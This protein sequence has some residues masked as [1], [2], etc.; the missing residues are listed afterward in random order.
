MKILEVLDKFIEYQTI[1]GLTD[2]TLHHNKTHIEFFVLWWGNKDIKNISFEDYQKYIL[3]LRGKKKK[4]SKQKLSSRTIY[5]YAEAL[6]SFLKFSFDKGYIKENVYSEIKLPKFQKKTIQILT[7]TQ[8][9][10]ILFYYDK[11][12]FYGARNLFIISLMLDCGLRLSEVIKLSIF[13][14]Q[15]A[16]RTIKVN[17][18]GQKQRLVPLTDATLFYFNNYL[19]Q[20]E[21]SSFKPIMPLSVD[22]N[23]LGITENAI[24][25]FLWRMRKD[26]NIPNLHPHLLRHTFATMFLLN[27]G[28]PLHLQIILG[29]TT[30]TMTSHY[31]HIANQMRIAEQQIYSPL[32]KI[33]VCHQ[34]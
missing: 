3:Y 20:F 32:N 10:D 28:D 8:I 13:D 24:K 27:G 29:H 23:C 12:T 25:C 16:N 22:I 14:F 6:K 9:K 33:P 18:K 30:L 11:N 1:L 15:V 31:V 26:L 2:K 5:T 21:N 17:G 4:D 19:S 34:N 7:E